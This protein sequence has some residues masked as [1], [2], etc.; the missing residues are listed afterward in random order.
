MKITSINNPK[1]AYWAKLKMKKYRDVEHL[2]I[3]ESENLVKE[4]KKKGIVKEI[5]TTED[6]EYKVDTYNYLLEISSYV[7]SSTRSPS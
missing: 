1:V 4:K 2:F 6:K 5:I 7:N 3:V